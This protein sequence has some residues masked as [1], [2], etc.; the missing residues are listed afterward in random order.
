MIFSFKQRDKVRI[1]KL[2]S[3]LN[4]T[5]SRNGLEDFSFFSDSIKESILQKS[6]TFMPSQY[7][8]S[9]IQFTDNLI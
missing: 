6:K 3:D 8:K 1:E 9:F 5:I 2:R 7:V 4:L